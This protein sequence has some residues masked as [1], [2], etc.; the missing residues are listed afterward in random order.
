MNRKKLATIVLLSMLGITNVATLIVGNKNVSTYNDLI[1]SKESII[2]QLNTVKED[3]EQ[4]LINAE[5]QITDTEKEKDSLQQELNKVLEGL[6]DTKEQVEKLQNVIDEMNK[7]VTF[8][9]GDVR[10]TSG[11]TEYHLKKAL[12]GTSL[13]SLAGAFVQAEQNYGI[14]AYFLASIVALESGWG[15]SE[16]ANNGSNNLTGYA[17]YSDHS[18]GKYFSSKEECVFETA[19][20]LTEDY[21]TPNG[22]YF[23]DGYSSYHVNIKYS[24]DTNWCNKV[25]DITYTLLE[26]SNK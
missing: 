17:V 21:L 22:I 2:K 19:R 10:I 11:A 7:A 14:N 4:Q 5:N 20:L 25:E 26:L 8:N 6:K 13:Y 3:L 1:S 24:E 18:P 12:L 16:R 23:S 9:S 15:E